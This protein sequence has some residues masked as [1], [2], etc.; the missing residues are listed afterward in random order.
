MAVNREECLRFTGRLPL[1][2]VYENLEEAKLT[3]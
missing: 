3:F 1:S 2:E